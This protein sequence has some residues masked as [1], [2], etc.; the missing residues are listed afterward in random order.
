MTGAPLV[1]VDGLHRVFDVSKSSS[2]SPLSS[3]DIIKNQKVNKAL[4]RR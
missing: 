4:Q 2:P 1:V 3:F